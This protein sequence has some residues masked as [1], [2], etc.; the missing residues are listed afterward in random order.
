MK[1]RMPLLA[2]VATVVFALTAPELSA[3]GHGAV[4]DGLEGDRD[5]SGTAA[6]QKQRG[7]S[8]VLNCEALP[9]RGSFEAE[10][11]GFEP[12]VDFWPTQH[13]QCCT[14]GRS[15]TSPTTRLYAH[16]RERLP[17]RPGLS[18]HASRAPSRP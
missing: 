6:R 3:S 15:V 13:F 9:T 10:R 12:A 11:A 4:M 16:V 1:S 14:F 2:L 18:G 5:K 7:S 17:C 8:Q